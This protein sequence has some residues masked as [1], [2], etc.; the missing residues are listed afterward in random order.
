M[1]NRYF[2]RRYFKNYFFYGIKYALQENFYFEK[3]TSFF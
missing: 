1:I 3:D 2:A